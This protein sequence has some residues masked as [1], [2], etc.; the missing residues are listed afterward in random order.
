MSRPSALSRIETVTARMGKLEAQRDTAVA[1]ALDSGATWA[2][3]GRAL[4][5]SAQAAHKRFRWIRRSSITGEVRHESPL[6]V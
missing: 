4:G 6:P 5:V 3:I 1:E 2:E